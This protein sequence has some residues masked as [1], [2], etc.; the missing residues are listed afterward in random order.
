M[1][2]AF[3]AAGTIK[4]GTSGN[5]SNVVLPTH[6]AGDL[7]V[8]YILTSD[9]VSIGMGTSGY[10][11]IFEQNNGTGLRMTLCWKG[12]AGAETNPSFTHTAG[13]DG[14]ARLFSFTGA[15]TTNPFP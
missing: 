2:V 8:G 5:F 12:D 15:D 6:A 10:T 9:N 7:L 1:A 4:T 11:K 13:A 3:K 14:C